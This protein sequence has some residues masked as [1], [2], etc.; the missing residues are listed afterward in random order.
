[1]STLTDPPTPTLHATPVRKFWFDEVTAPATPA[2][3]R[4]HRLERLAGAF[5]LFAR[6]GFDQGL[7]GH[8]TARDPEWPDHFWVNPLGRHFAR[9]RASD[10]LLVNSTGEI[11]VGKGPVNQAAFA[12]HAAF[13]RLVRILLLRRIRIRCMEKRGRPWVASSIRSRRTLARSMRI[14]NYST[15]SRVWCS[16]RRKARV[17]PR[18][19]VRAKR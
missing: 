19:W 7:A 16:T 13:T 5:R 9:M 11:V 18:R 8:I 2:A 12:I 3:E 15:I 10:L 14:T 4:R 17:L 6:Y 1:M